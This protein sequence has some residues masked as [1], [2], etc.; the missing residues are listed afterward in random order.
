MLLGKSA[1]KQPDHSAFHLWPQEPL[2]RREMWDS[3]CSLLVSRVS[4]E[5]CPIWYT[6]TGYVSLRDGLLA[7]E[8]A[9]PDQ[10]QAFRDAGIPVIY[11]NET[12]LKHAINNDKGRKL[13]QR[14]VF[15]YLRSSSHLLTASSE[16]KIVLLEYLSSELPITEIAG[17]AVFPFEDGTLQV[18]NQHGV[19]L[20]RDTSERELFGGTPECNLDIDKLSAGLLKELRQRAAKSSTSSLRLRKPND[21]QEYC[22]KT[23]FESQKLHKSLDLIEVDQEVHTFVYR[24]WKW[25]TSFSSTKPPLTAIGQL[26]LLPLTNGKCRKVQPESASLLVTY[27]EV[28]NERDIMMKLARLEPGSAPLILDLDAFPDQ[29]TPLLRTM[30]KKPN[31][32]IR[33]AGVFIHFLEWLVEGRH[34][35]EM[36]DSADKKRVLDAVVDWFWSTKNH[37]KLAKRSLRQ[38]CI[39]KWLRRGESEGPL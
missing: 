12:I 8:Y 18:I 4:L 10:R 16:S 30:S 20:H 19:F 34:L 13:C 7:S 24:V 11:L 22:D 38:L 28:K 1:A 21:L 26:S 31:M 23:A 39:F 29:S 37:E 2:K 14:T 35:L 6:D 5:G 27:T 33:N 9:F 3:L 36:A 15:E 25:I 32:A 17:L